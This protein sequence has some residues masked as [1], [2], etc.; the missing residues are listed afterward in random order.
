MSQDVQYKVLTTFEFEETGNGEWKITKY[1]GFDFDEENI[2]IPAQIGDKKIVALGAKL[3]AHNERIKR[4][5]LDPGIK[6][7]ENRAFALCKSLEQIILPDTLETIEE[8]AFLGTALSELVLP[9]SIVKLGRGVC[10][11]CTVYNSFC[12]KIG[13]L[14]KVVLPEGLTEIPDEAFFSCKVLEHIN[15][16]KSIKRIGKTAFEFCEN[17]TPF[18]FHDGLETIGERAFA[19][20]FSD[21]YED[22]DNSLGMLLI[23][24]SIK[25]IEK[26]AFEGCNIDEI[27]FIQGCQAKL[28]KGAFANTWPASMYI[29]ASIT[30]IGEI[31]LGTHYDS[32]ECKKRDEDGKIVRDAWGNDVYEKRRYC[33]EEDQF[34]K[35]MIIYCELGSTAFNFAKSKGIKCADYESNFHQFYEHQKQYKEDKE[36]REA[37]QLAK[38]KEKQER[39]DRIAQERVIASDAFKT[40]YDK[41]E[42]ASDPLTDFVNYGVQKLKSFL[43]KFKK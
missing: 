42:A 39:L 20:T 26:S 40:E 7:I 3:F 41:C 36:K 37:E 14:T 5:K 13:G 21:R 15:I 4:V 19:F 43:D 34:S 9:S 22:G 28:E 33:K 8:C 38:E 6:V 35:E 17:L 23:P 24:K 27:A 1:I 18:E 30:N 12:E 31:F 32:Y 16:P 10:S 25:H 11:G 29:P 2:E